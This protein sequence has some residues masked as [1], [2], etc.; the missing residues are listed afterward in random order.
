M[1]KS[2]GN[3]IGVMDPPGE[4]FGKIMSIS[5]DLMWRYFELLSNI[6]ATDLKTLRDKA[7]NGEMNPKNVKVQLGKELV[8]RYHSEEAAEQAAREFENVFKDKNLPTDIP[9]VKTWSG[10]PRW[11]GKVLA[12]SKVCPSTS[13]AKRM[14]K[15]GAVSVDGEKVTDENLALNG[16]REYLIKVGKKRFLK[17]TP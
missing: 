9:T 11:I 14:I 5:D 2:L 3:S 16:G 13:D 8:A 15:Q 12:D 17:I 10:E 6:K 7:A 1:S 4:M